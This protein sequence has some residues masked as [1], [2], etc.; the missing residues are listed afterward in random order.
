MALWSIKHQLIYNNT[1]R[2]TQPSPSR[3]VTFTQSAQCPPVVLRQGVFALRFCNVDALCHLMSL[4]RAR[5]RVP[6]PQLKRVLTDMLTW[7]L[8]LAQA[9][10]QFY[11][12]TMAKGDASRELTVTPPPPP[13]HTHTQA[14]RL[15]L[16]SDTRR[17]RTPPGPSLGVL[18]NSR[19]R[20]VWFLIAP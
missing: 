14:C 1:A 11:D 4:S 5:F 8:T 20:K 15:R 10:D 9:I 3:G 7:P 17:A 6:P 2:I 16:N 19:R 13:T 12:A 18:Q